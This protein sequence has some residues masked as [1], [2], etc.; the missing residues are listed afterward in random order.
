MNVLIRKLKIAAVVAMA[1]L[2]PFALPTESR[3]GKVVIGS[4]PT[5][6]L[7]WIAEE[8]RYF[9]ESGTNVE[10]RAFSSG[11]T[12]SKALAAGELNLANSSEFAFVNNAMRNRD[13]RM[14]A[15]ISRTNSANLFARKDSGIQEA[16]DLVGRKIGVTK[17]GNGE[18][19]LGE[20]LSIHG[21]SIT[22]VELVD[23]RPPAIV[24]SM[25]EGTIDAAITW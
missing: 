24:E 22:D 15:S 16:A 20:Y 6:H 21:I 5:G 14:I 11:V 19:F 4:T 12:A 25:V 3:A 13:L 1:A 7:M 9:K 23:L 8:L 2:A 10:L 17:R 18:F